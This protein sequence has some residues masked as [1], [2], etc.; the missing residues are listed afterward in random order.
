MVATPPGKKPEEAV[1][2][3]K[4]DKVLE[5]RKEYLARAGYDEDAAKRLAESPRVD[6]HRAEALLVQGCPPTTALLILL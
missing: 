1:D 5:W 3:V 2:K 6:L 4:V